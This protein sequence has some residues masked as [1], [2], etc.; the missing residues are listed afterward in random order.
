MIQGPGILDTLYGVEPYTVGLD[1]G[2]ESDFL[3]AFALQS[4]NLPRAQLGIEICC[5]LPF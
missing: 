1:G 3:A 4:F 2:R 5:D